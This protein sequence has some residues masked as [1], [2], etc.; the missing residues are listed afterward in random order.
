MNIITRQFGK[1]A[2]GILLSKSFHE[3]YANVKYC[4][5]LPHYGQGPV[6]QSLIKLTPD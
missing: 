5:V 2:T 4:M 6:V 3:K 1:K